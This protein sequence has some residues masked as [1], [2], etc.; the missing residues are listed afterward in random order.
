MV[1]KLWL[2][3]GQSHQV[4]ANQD[5][6]SRNESSMIHNVSSLQNIVLKKEKKSV[7]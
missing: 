1:G 3:V 6:W 7:L 4:T 5:T 2:K